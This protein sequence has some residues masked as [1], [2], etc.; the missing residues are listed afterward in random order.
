MEPLVKYRALLE[1]LDSQIAE[2]VN[3]ANKPH[4]RPSVKDTWLDMASGIS[5]A[6]FKIMQAFE[7]G[8]I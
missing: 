2:Y 6:K 7:N 3:C 1:L 4:V 8:D 5:L